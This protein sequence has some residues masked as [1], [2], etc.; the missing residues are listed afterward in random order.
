MRNV[1]LVLD[2]AARAAQLGPVFAESAQCS[3]LACARGTFSEITV[4]IVNGGLVV[5]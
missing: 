4:Y 3:G 1:G 5:L 2:V